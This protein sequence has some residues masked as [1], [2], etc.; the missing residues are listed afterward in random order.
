MTILKV[1]MTDAN[2]PS[3]NEPTRRDFL[4]LTAGA[5]G[6]AGVACAA[7]PLVGSLAPAADVLAL[8][9]TEVDIS[10]IAVGQS[11]TVMWRGKPVFIRHRSAEEIASAKADDGAE[12]RDPQTDAIRAERPEWLVL[13]GQCTHLGC[14]PSGQKMSDNKGD[15]NG[16]FCP[17]HGSHYD[18]SGRIRKGPAPLNLA[19]PPYKFVSD[20]KILI[21]QA[22]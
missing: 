12:M 3:S 15:Y 1:S 14:V 16:W 7:V 17:C 8:A 22:A 13:V 20:T 2:T 5:V 19:V 9:N 4:S 21:G 10:K 11:T 18:A 6:V